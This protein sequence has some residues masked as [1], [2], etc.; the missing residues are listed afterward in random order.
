M[1]QF[2]RNHEPLK[3]YHFISVDIETNN[4]E[5]ELSIYYNF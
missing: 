3:N 4:D 2:N 1:L 5:Q